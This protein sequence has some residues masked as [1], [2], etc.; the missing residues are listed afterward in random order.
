MSDDRLRYKYVGILLLVAFIVLV[1]S[2]SYVYGQT[3][4][5]NAGKPAT[6]DNIVP[7]S[8]K[9]CA[10]CLCCDCNECGYCHGSAHM[11]AKCKGKCKCC[12]ECHCQQ[13]ASVTSILKSTKNMASPL[14]LSTQR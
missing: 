8:G 7:G 14:S 3:A 4:G 6:A 1:V 9:H 12:S 13:P 11:N 2:C 10:C 5:T